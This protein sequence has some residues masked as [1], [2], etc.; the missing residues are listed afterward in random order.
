MNENLESLVARYV[1]L[2]S[3]EVMEELAVVSDLAIDARALPVLR[4]RLQEEEVSGPL[5]AERGYERMAEKSAQLQGV[6]RPL[7]AVLEERSDDAA[8]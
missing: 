7:V 3:I 2:E 6:L 1:A 4:R 5:L 8:R